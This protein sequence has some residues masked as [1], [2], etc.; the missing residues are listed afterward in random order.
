MGCFENVAEWTLLVTYFVMDKTTML[1]HDAGVTTSFTACMRWCAHCILQC[2]LYATLHF[3]LL[4]V[5]V[6][7]YCMQ[8]YGYVSY[9]V[10]YA[11]VYYCRLMCASDLF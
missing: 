4:D 9:Y 1:E 11:I 2:S 7:L 6:F 8:L 10:L 5:T 3:V